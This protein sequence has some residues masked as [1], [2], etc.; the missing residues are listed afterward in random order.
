MHVEQIL[1]QLLNEVTHKTRVKS[2][3]PVIKAVIE[4]KELRL[5]ELG[6]HLN[7]PGQERAAIRRVDRLL[8][9]KHYQDNFIEIYKAITSCA[10]GNQ[11]R[12]II[13][14]DWSGIPNSRYT[15]NGGEQSLLRAALLAEGRSITLYQEVHSKKVE[16][17]Q[18]VHNAFLKKL[19]SILPECCRPYIVT[20][21]GFKNPWFR[22]VLAYGWDYIGRVRGTVHYDDG[23]GFKSIK[24]LFKL[25]GKEPKSLGHYKLSK[26][27]P[28]KTSFYAYKH[29]LVGRKKVT[30]S[31]KVDTHKDS[32]NYS[33]SYREPWILVSSLKGFSAIKRAVNIYKTR[34]TIE[35]SFRDNKS[36]AFGLKLN[37]NV[38]I[39]EK[40]Y[41]VWL[42]LA[43]LACFIAWIVGYAAEQLKLHYTFQA[44]TYRHRRVLSFFYLGCQIVR[45][46]IDIP[47]QL[48]LICQQAF[49]ETAWRTL[50]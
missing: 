42:M 16:N 9:N 10:A 43:A 33:K 36:T 8:A 37:E 40:R 13:L 12:P 49:D 47:I 35:G 28:L 6:R 11:G 4:S 45:K 26:D 48:D 3:I 18:A 46:K 34:M 7:T 17:H 50:C 32:I 21:A 15:A 29:K 38:T 22:A 30:R 19:Q 23:T 20:D 1:T 27:K 44:N 24:H 41:T 14:V 31:G 39:K 2:L 25:A 5:T